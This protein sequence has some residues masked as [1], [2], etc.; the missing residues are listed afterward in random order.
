MHGKR[1]LY[2][3]LEGTCSWM[4]AA[5]REALAVVVLAAVRGV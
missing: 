3:I 4:H 2:R 1:V 5:R